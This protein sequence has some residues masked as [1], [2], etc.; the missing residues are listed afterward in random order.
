MGF[1]VQWT[2]A[3]RVEA[4]DVDGGL[5]QCLAAQRGFLAAARH[6]PRIDAHSVRV[7]EEPLRECVNVR[8]ERVC[9]PA[10][11]PPHWFADCASHWAQGITA[12]EARTVILGRPYLR[13]RNIRRVEVSGN[14]H[15]VVRIDVYL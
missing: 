13:G 2:E 11:S 7:V 3:G 4:F 8:G 15:D 1:R 6:D 14:S 5:E 10:V 12:A 9:E